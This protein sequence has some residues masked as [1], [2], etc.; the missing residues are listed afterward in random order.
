MKSKNLLVWISLLGFIMAVVLA[1]CSSASAADVQATETIGPVVADLKI[2]AEGKVVPVRNA[3]LS[4][5][6]GGVVDD[7]FCEEGSSV[8]KGDEIA[9]LSGTER[10]ESQI[11]SAELAVVSA[12][13]AYDNLFENVDV[14]KAQAEVAV[15]QAKITLE[16]A[17]DERERRNYRQ[18]SD[19]TLDGIRADQIIAK[20]ALDDAEEYY[21]YFEDNYN[22]NDPVRAGALSQLVAAKKA[23]EKENY[24][25]QYAL[26]YPDAVDIEEADADVA[27]AL[28]NLTQAENDLEALQDGKPDP[29][30]VAMADAKLKEANASLAAAQAALEDIKLIAPFDGELVANNLTVGEFIAP[31]S[32]AA[33]VGDIS[34]W[35]I[36][37]TDLTELD[38]VNIKE[39]M[40]VTVE[41]DA[42]PGVQLKGIVSSVKMLGEN[43]Q[44]DITYTVKVKLSEQDERLNWNMTAFVTFPLE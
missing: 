5:T 35:E 28:A 20:N 12:Q 6:S 23:Y 16:D 15:A 2:V 34:E 38:V 41:F 33:V 31:G 7:I 26:G 18:S 37:T 24:N 4:F 39:G 25:L 32:P 36:E 21:N 14:Q 42:L 44:G 3:T 40:E 8:K 10:L 30:D 29:D 43:Y 1:G 11:S 22:E 9:Q 13:Q 17:Q 19:T 27:L